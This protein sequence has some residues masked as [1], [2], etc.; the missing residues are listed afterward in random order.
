MTT[1]TLGTAF[2]QSNFSPVRLLGDDWNMHFKQ[3]ESE[4]I[5]SYVNFFYFPYL[6]VYVETLLGYGV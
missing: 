1:L 3:K 5:T 2:Y 6:G 4:R